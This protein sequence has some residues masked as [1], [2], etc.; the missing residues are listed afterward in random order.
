MLTINTI[1]KFLT[2]WYDRK[3]FAEIQHNINKI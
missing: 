3:A 2:E 1:V